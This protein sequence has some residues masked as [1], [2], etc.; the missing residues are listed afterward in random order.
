MKR[1]LI[2]IFLKL[3]KIQTAIEA[4]NRRSTP[5]LMR[6]FRLKRLHL[7]MQDRLARLFAQ[8]P[9]PV[10]IP[11]YARARSRAPHGVRRLQ[12]N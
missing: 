4:E 7:M 9:Q 1:R 2:G 10:L 6:L 12:I 11:A 5:S 8:E 3:A